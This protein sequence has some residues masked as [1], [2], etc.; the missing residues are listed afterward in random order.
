VVSDAALDRYLM[1]QLKACA[2]VFGIES[3]LYWEP[4]SYSAKE[5]AAARHL[6]TYRS[7]GVA[8]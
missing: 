5:R 4:S 6:G 7:V 8:G 1:I 3:P 2:T